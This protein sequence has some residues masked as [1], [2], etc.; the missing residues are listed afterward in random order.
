VP[1]KVIGIG[2]NYKERF[3]G[4][5]DYP[6]FPQPFFKLP[7][8]VNRHLGQIVF[9]S[10]MK[11]ALFEAELAVI[12]GKRCKNVDPEDVRDHLLGYTC[13]NDV[14]GREI[15]DDGESSVALVKGPDTFCGLG[16]YIVLAQNFDASD[17]LI[18]CFVNGEL[19]QQSRTSNLVFGVSEI[20]S[21]LSR[22]FTLEPGD[23]VTT[24]TPPECEKLKSGDIVDVM[25]ENVGTLRNFVA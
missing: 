12:M 22:S 18:Q 8:S 23:V 5:E 4:P 2:Y 11:T 1:S 17:L 13:C 3:A 6:R 9:P 19:R 24:G 14:S 21:F 16:P 7:T 25:I 10:I 20:V 15:D